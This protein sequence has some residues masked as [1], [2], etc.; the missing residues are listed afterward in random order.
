M[1]QIPLVVDIYLLPE[2][3]SG[4]RGHR[5]DCHGERRLSRYGIPGERGEDNRPVDGVHLRGPSGRTMTTESVISILQMAGLAREER[6]NSPSDDIPNIDDWQVFEAINKT[7]KPKSGVPGDLPRK[8]VQEFAAELATPVVKIFRGI[9]RTN[10]WPRD[11]AIE[12]GIAQ[13]KCPNPGTEKNVRLISLTSLWSKTMV[14][15]AQ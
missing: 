15:M 3:Y 1:R 7:K 5:L 8:I 10:T 13:K 9:M 12:H 4:K 6:E 11:W 14:K 2:D